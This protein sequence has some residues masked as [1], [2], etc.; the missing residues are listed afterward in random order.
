[1]SEAVAKACLVCGDST[2]YSH[3]GVDS[4][5]ACADFYKRTISTGKQYACRQGN[6]QCKL[7]KS[8]MC[9]RCRFEKCVE[10]GMV[11]ARAKQ[12]QADDEIPS[13]VSTST[14]Q[15]EAK[16]SETI[17]YIIGREHKALAARCKFT[18]LSM[19]SKAIR[20]HVKVQ[21]DSEDLM[22]CTWPFLMECLRMNTVD[23]FRLAG[24]AFPEFNALSMEEKHIMLQSYATRLYILETHYLTFTMFKRDPQRPCMITFTTC[25]DFDNLQFFIQNLDRSAPH[26]D[27]IK[28]MAYYVDRMI[29]VVWPLMLKSDLSEMEYYALFG[30]VMWQLDPCQEISEKLHA[31]AETIRTSIYTDLHR[32][33]REE[34]NLDDYCGR[35]GNILLLEHTIQ[36]ANALKSEEMQTYNLL[37]MLTAD[38][39]FLQLVM[40]I[41]F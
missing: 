32:Y 38:V 14:C 20:E 4:C 3:Y 30:L 28:S 41:A 34:L 26:G 10:L 7:S 29:S 25:L 39:S 18:E 1:M 27:I 11:N 2:K 12:S 40:Q 33:Y 36:E 17:L 16:T 19:R 6:G 13:V 37:D 15:P 5:R 8:A 31:I 21:H 24:A 22:L 9:R 23:Y 35:M